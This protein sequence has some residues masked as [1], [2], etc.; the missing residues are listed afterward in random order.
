[1]IG[2]PNDRPRTTDGVG[3]LLHALARRAGAAPCVE[4]IASTPWASITFTGMRHAIALRFDGAD[5]G[6]RTQAMTAGLDYAEFDLGSYILVDIAVVE[7]DHGDGCAR[8]TLEALV[9]KGD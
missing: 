2:A 5:A 9:I 7:R 1:M 4:Q 3:A 6:A 8:L